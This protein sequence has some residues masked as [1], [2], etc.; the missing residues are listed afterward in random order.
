MNGPLSKKKLELPPLSHSPLASKR[1]APSA[2]HRNQKSPTML[3]TSGPP[4][5]ESAGLVDDPTP[6]PPPV[7]R[8]VLLPTPD[9]LPCPRPI[10]PAPEL[11]FEPLAL[12]QQ[13]VRLQ[14]QTSC[15]MEFNTLQDLRSSPMSSRSSSSRS[16]SASFPSPVSPPPPRSRTK[17]VQAH[18]KSTQKHT[19][20]TGG[21]ISCLIARKNGFAGY[22]NICNRGKPCQKCVERGLEKKCVYP[23]EKLDCT[24]C[25]KTVAKCSREVPCE[26]CRDL[27]LKNRRGGPLVCRYTLP[28]GLED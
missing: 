22:M 23:W 13:R 16:S 10:S 24:S 27:N 7:L 2:R 20:R 21:C 4:T 26:R 25:R 19:S 3:Q 9:L 15:D 17:N 28:Q 14:P 6:T 12:P 1:A 11:H 8:P 18:R 5:I